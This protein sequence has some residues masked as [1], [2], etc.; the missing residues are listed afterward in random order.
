VQNGA[1]AILSFPGMWLLAALD[2]TPFF[3]LPF[4]IDAAVVVVASQHPRLFWFCGISAALASLPGA[5]LTLHIGKRVGEVGLRR[6]MTDARLDAVKRR[7]HSSGA[8]GLALLDLVPPPFPFTACIL[9]AGA[10]QVN[11][12]KFLVT[13]LLGRLV[14]FGLESILGVLLGPRI[15]EWQAS[16]ELILGFKVL[17][18]L[19]LAVGLLSVILG[20]RRIRHA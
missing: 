16:P 3:K 14:R 7:V 4:G 12:T 13:L 11:W 6:L 1:L 10:L 17:L 9:A 20:L 2:S 8:V 5:L 15:L 19:A 18:F